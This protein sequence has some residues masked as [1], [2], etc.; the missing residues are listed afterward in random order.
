MAVA[1]RRTG[2]LDVTLEWYEVAGA[3]TVGARRHL[4]ALRRNSRNAFG[5]E[6]EGGWE[7]HIEGACAERA[8]AKSLGVYWDGSVNTYARADIVTL[9][10]VKIQVRWRS[11]DSY[12]LMVRP[13]DSDTERF[14][15]V[16]GTVPTYRVWGWIMGRD[17]KRPNWSHSHGGRPAAF[18]VPK[19]E[20]HGFDDWGRNVG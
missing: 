15:L 10:G 6:D 17:A 4:E 13:K 16:T 20:L 11:K 12:D 2:P 5:C 7:K 8:A 19:D 14:V 1:M 9:D 3:V 18:F